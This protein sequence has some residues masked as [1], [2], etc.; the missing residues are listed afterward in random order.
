LL[1]IQ[2]ETDSNKLKQ[3]F[4]VMQQLSQNKLT[5][6]VS[7]LSVFEVLE[8]LAKEQIVP[9]KLERVEPTLENLFM[10]VTH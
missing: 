4:P 6:C 5:F 9:L 10:E 7:E 8:Y 2:S 3:A 1:E